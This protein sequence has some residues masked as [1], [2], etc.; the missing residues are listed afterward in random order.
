MEKIESI[1]KEKQMEKSF[2]ALL[3][4]NIELADKEYVL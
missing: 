4:F 3:D 2:K 1:V